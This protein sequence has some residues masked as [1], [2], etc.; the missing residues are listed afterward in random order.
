MRLDTNPHSPIQ[1]RV[2]GEQEPLTTIDADTDSRLLFLQG[3]WNDDFDMRRKAKT[4]VFYEV[5]SRGVSIEAQ[6]HR[7]FVLAMYLI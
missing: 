5:A 2:E 4:G 7:T 3:E 1:D 6:I